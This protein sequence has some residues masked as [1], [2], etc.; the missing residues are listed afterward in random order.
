MERGSTRSHSGE[1]AL[2]EAV[3]LSQDKLQNDSLFL[4]NMGSS[5]VYTLMYYFSR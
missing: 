5:V 3:D 1:L 4:S 2:E